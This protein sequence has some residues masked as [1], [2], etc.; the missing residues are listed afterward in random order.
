MPRRDSA[1]L[2]LNVAVCWAIIGHLLSGRLF[3][4]SSYH[5]VQ[6]RLYLP[7]KLPAKRHE[8]S[9]GAGLAAHCSVR[10]ISIAPYL[11]GCEG[12]DPCDR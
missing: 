12:D 10:A 1:K 6:A 8:R 5:P 4:V 2:G 11:G 3:H 9:Q 7:G